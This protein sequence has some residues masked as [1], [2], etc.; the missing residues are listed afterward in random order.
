[1]ILLPVL[2]LLLGGGY[3]Y[4]KYLKASVQKGVAI[5]SSIWFTSNYAFSVTEHTA[6]DD[7][8]G[9][10]KTQAASTDID[11]RNYAFTVDIRNYKNILVFN[12][13]SEE[14]PYTISFWLSAPQAAGDTY[15]VTPVYKDRDAGG[16][17]VQTIGTAKSISSDTKAEFTHTPGLPGGEALEDEYRIN[18]SVASA[19]PVS[20][21]VMAKTA[22]G[23]LLKETLKGEIVLVKGSGSGEFLRSAGFVTNS[24]SADE[25]QQLNALKAQSEFTYKIVTGGADAGMNEFTL[26]WDPDVYEIDRFS[27]A[28]MA[29]SEEHSSEAPDT[30]WGPAHTA[31]GELNTVGIAIPDGEENWHEGWSAKTN[32]ITIKATSYASVSVGFFRAGNFQSDA[33]DSLDKFSKYVHVA[34]GKPA[35]VTP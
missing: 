5:A 33:M 11:G 32:Y 28:Y 29:W 14:I 21:Y 3:A 34:K 10:M 6:D 7:M 25:A 9:V 27:N 8:T 31:P 26:Y 2:T 15:T 12:N 30:L 16:N 22:D 17:I 18:I 4:A 23:A 35:G 13:S 19:A 20:I 1:M 24:D